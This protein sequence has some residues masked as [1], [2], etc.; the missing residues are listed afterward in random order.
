MPLESSATAI[1]FEHVTR[2]FGVVVAVDDVTLSVGAG[3]FFSML[4]PSGSGKTTC[5]RLIAGFEQ[6][7]AGHIE[8]FGETAD[9]IPPYRRAVNTVF[10][11][12]ALFPH[13]SV[14]DNVAYGLMVRGL[15]KQPRRGAAREMLALVKLAGLEERRPAELSGGQRQRVALARA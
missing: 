1:R 8:I 5:L 2:R 14:L 3:E 15:S 10:Q 6:P 13:M 9:G 4:G 7:D 11:D 12:Y